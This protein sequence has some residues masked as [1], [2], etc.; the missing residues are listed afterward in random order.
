[1]RRMRLRVLLAVQ[2]GDYGSALLESIRLHV[3][4]NQ[5]MV[6]QEE[7]ALAARHTRWCAGHDCP[8]RWHCCARHDHRYETVI[9]DVSRQVSYYRCFF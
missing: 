7:T 2:E 4:G 6:A 5:A 1:M 8:S 3:L 9:E